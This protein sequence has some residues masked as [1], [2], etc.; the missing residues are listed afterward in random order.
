MLLSFAAAGR[1]FPAGAQTGGRLAVPALAALIP[2]LACPPPTPSVLLRPGPILLSL[3]L[4]GADAG[5][6]L[7]R[8]FPI[9]EMSSI[10]PA[11]WY[12]LLLGSPQD[13]WGTV[14]PWLG[15]YRHS[16]SA[17]PSSEE[18]AGGTFL[19]LWLHCSSARP[20]HSPHPGSCLPQALPPGLLHSTPSAGSGCY[21]HSVLFC[22]AWTIR[23][24][25]GT[26]GI[27]VP[28]P[29]PGLNHPL[30]DC[31]AD[32]GA[33]SASGS[34]QTS[35]GWGVFLQTWNSCVMAQLLPSAEER[36]GLSRAG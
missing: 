9:L 17:W 31:E 29:S 3:G 35:H 10:Q 30:R 23:T 8:G 11:Q 24:K 28:R 26:D 32:S 22:G 16:F 15:S 18:G 27:E 14:V 33:H 25:H 34:P 1:P 19:R 2:S 6:K 21:V 12:H 7:P 20:T 36:C 4:G 5:G 13:G